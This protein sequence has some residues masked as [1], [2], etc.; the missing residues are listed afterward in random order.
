MFDAGYWLR[1][2][3]SGVRKQMT[4]DRRQRTVA[5]GEAWGVGIDRLA[6]PT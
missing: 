3:F 2:E 5:P 6:K 4:E 1:K